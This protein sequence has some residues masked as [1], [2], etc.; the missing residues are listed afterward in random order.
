MLLL[1]IKSPGIGLKRSLLNAKCV[2][3]LMSWSL[4]PLSRWWLLRGC[5][6]WAWVGSAPT[7]WISGLYVG[8]AGADSGLH[9]HPLYRW[10][11]GEHLFAG[12]ACMQGLSCSWNTG[13]SV[14]F[15]IG[16]S[17]FVIGFKITCL[18]GSDACENWD[19]ADWLESSLPMVHAA[20]WSLG[21]SNSHSRGFRILSWGLHIWR[22]WFKV[23]H[24]TY[25][26]A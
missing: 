12:W 13:S 2:P 5:C 9:I 26:S 14:R 11:H 25:C 15:W 8:P 17:R 22:L 21:L 10:G 20:C 23:I 18:L 7:L 16:R 24:Q 19:E 1:L 6:R 4:S 3:G